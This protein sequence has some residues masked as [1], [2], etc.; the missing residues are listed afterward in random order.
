MTPG[1]ELFLLYLLLRD[2]KEKKERK[3]KT[4]IYA[5]D[6]SC[7]LNYLQSAEER[8]REQRGRKELTNECT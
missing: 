3:E 5:Y 2:T 1:H 7:L 6:A 4:G 8:E